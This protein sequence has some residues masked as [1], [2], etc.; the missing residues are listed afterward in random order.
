MV[1]VIK[2]RQFLITLF[3]LLMVVGNVS[4]QK[5]AG[6]AEKWVTLVDDESTTISYNPKIT[7]L[8]NGHHIVWVKAVHK[9]LDWQQYFSNMIGSRQLVKV[10]KTKAEYD[11][12]CSFA[13]VRQVLCYNKAG[14]L[15]YNTGE[16]TSA[17]WYP[18]NASDPV[19][20]VGEHLAN[21]YNSGDDYNDY[22][23]W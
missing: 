6:Q 19:G 16:S 9:T 10:T 5:K 2:K 1:F 7:D 17:G 8:R 12:I 13:L 20:I 18:V 23:D 11:E 22:G 4:A 14:K 15:I 3:C 21:K